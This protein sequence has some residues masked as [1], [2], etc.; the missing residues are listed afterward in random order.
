MAL[1]IP[2]TTARCP[3]SSSF[4]TRRCVAGSLA[5]PG[6]AS[7]G[8]SAPAAAAAA[9]GDSGGP[10]SGAVLPPPLPT[11]AAA[12]A[13][14]TLGVAPPDCSFLLEDHKAAPTA[15]LSRR[16]EDRETPSPAIRR[17]AIAILAANSCGSEFCSNCRAR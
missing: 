16:E 1:L 4:S 7:D 11:S 14:A 12:A 17:W 15:A 8:V 13:T 2:C 5:A 10:R 9:A 6:L 3:A